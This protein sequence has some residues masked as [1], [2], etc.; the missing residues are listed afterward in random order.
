VRQPTL[1]DL[2]CCAGGAAVGYHRAGFRV[3][4]YDKDP[5]PNYPFE[6]RQADVLSLDPEALQA[7]ADALHASPPCQHHSRTANI[8]PEGRTGGYK[9]PRA[10]AAKAD[11]PDLINPTRDLLNATGLPWIMEN[12]PEAPLRNPVILCG[13]MFGLK[14]YRHRKFELNWPLS[15]S[16]PSHGPHDGWT[17]TT[18]GYSSHANGAS[19][20]TVAGKNFNLND[21]KAAMGVDWAA[22]QAEVAQMIP[23]AYTEWL[24][25]QLM[26]RVLCGDLI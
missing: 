25:R 23:P 13:L 26:G 24:G 15:L 12:V 10:R 20:I 1:I 2:Y 22:T 3:I 4:G 9:E 5:Q 19:M 16:L 14:V 21:G 11:H 8:H 17:N 7:E 18:K 6:F